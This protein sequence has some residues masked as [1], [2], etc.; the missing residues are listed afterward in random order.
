VIDFTIE[1]HIAR[2]VE[3]VFAYATDP[4]RLPSWQTNTISSELQTDPPLRLGS[5][6]REVHAAPG[7][8]E[9]TTLVEVSAYE[10]D[11]LFG[12]RVLDGALPLDATLTFQATAGGT[13][14]HFR[15]HGQPSGAMALAQPLLR[16]ILRR[17]FT[18]HCRALKRVLEQAHGAAAAQP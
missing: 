7:G 16:P 13:L 15:V 11:A 6:L 18:A 4:Q 10:P 8:R 17:Q 1:I 9:L 5:R 12:L 14:L 3:D 2:A